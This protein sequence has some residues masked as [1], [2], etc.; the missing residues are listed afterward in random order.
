[1]HHLILEYF[2]R[3]VNSKASKLVGEFKASH[4]VTASSFDFCITEASN[5]KCDYVQVLGNELASVEMRKSISISKPSTSL[6]LNGS[7]SARPQST[8]IYAEHSLS[9]VIS[10]Y[11]LTVAHLSLIQIKSSEG[12][13]RLRVQ[14]QTPTGDTIPLANVP[15]DGSDL[16]HHQQQQQPTNASAVKIAQMKLTVPVK[17]AASEHSPQANNALLVSMEA[18]F[19]VYLQSHWQQ[20]DSELSEGTLRIQISLKSTGEFAYS[21][22]VSALRFHKAHCCVC[23]VT[24]IKAQSAFLFFA[25]AGTAEEHRFTV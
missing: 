24:L 21:G 2:K 7:S 4:N 5:Y 9:T 16:H 3:K 19:A 12:K 22:L 17:V 1:M 20:A 18:Y 10:K 15:L 14:L 8:Y 13:S 6:W 25:I 23:S 11:K